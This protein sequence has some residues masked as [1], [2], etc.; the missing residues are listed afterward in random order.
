MDDPFTAALARHHAGDLPGAEQLYRTLLGDQP[1]HADALHLLGVLLHQTGRHEEALDL[2]T[3]S[4]ALVPAAAAYTNQGSVLRALGRLDAALASHDAA[5]RYAPDLAAAHMNKAE[6]LMALARHQD[7]LESCDRALALRADHVDT[8][9]R[10]GNALQALGRPAEALG[11]YDR[12]LALRPADVLAL[13]NRG[14]AL[15]ALGRAAEAVDC[16]DRALKVKSDA[17]THANRGNAL[18]ALGAHEPAVDSYARAIALGLDDAAV[19]YTQGNALLELGRAEDALASY[20][21]AVALRPAYVEAWNNRGNAL[22]ALSRYDDALASYARA[23]TLDPEAREARVNTG[24]VMQIVNRHPEAVICYDIVLAADADHVD[25]HWNGALC[26]L[27][28]GDFQQGWRAFEWRHR[29]MPS[30][31]YVE[32]LWLGQDFAPGTTILLHAEQGFGDTLQFCRYAPMVA[33]LGARVVIETQPELKRL[34]TGL[35]GVA[36]VVAQGEATGPFDLHCPLLSLPLAFGTTVETVP[37]TVPYLQADPVATAAWR[38]RLEG[39]PGVKVGLVWAGNPRSFNQIAAEMDRRRSFALEQYA[40][41]GGIPGVTLVS[42][43]KDAAGEQARMPPAGMVVHDWTA[44]LT[45]FAETAALVAALDLVIGVDTSVV[46]VAGALGVPVWILNRHGACWRWLRERTDTPWYPNA[47]LF[48]QV[49]TD[50]WG[51]VMAEVAEALRDV[52]ASG[53]I[54]PSAVIARSEATWRSR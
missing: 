54:S 28:L 6:V 51:P 37:D 2:L 26:R 10:R 46:H 11:S 25:A 30:R 15:E 1:G 20:D 9:V 38:A 53:V 27:A 29:L 35:P 36:L 14:V 50:E 42:L 7:A 24:N 3:R 13:S 49:R 39:L 43:Q 16:Y 4:L 45:D 31:G 23:L 34:L 41:L 48:R 5:L 18:H 47:R 22:R 19:W 40:P 12:A 21:R 17:R 44:E 32:P 52:A 8:W 33:A